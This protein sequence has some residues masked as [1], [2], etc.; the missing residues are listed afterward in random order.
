MGAEVVEVAKEVA[1]VHEAAIRVE[2]I[3]EVAE[4]VVAEIGTTVE[5]REDT[6]EVIKVDGEATDLGKI[7]TKAAVG[8]DKVAKAAT[9]VE[10]IGA[11]TISEVVIN[12]ATAAD[13]LEIISTPE[14]GPRLM[15]EDLWV[16]TQE[17]A[18][19]VVA[20]AVAVATAVAAEVT[21]A[22][23]E[24]TQL[25]VEIWVVVAEAEVVA[26]VAEGTKPINAARR[27][28]ALLQTVTPCLP[29]VY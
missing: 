3:G 9:I 21:K 23:T 14:E 18:A 24:E 6:A 11:T 28:T 4:A 17:E 7:R 29:L 10:E 16:E 5:T 20:E 19:A 22:A 8:V 1:E 12:K 25:E 13:L 15:P 2:V 26:A 27:N